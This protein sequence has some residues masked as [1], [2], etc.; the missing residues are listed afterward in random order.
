[1]KNIKFTPI[2]NKNI[3]DWSDTLHRL[4]EALALEKKEKQFVVD[5]G[6]ATTLAALAPLNAFDFVL[7][8]TLPS[9]A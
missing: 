3:A 5:R 8:L 4:N 9:W 7:C 1:M 6:L 2:S